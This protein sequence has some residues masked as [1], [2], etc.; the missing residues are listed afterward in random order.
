MPVSVAAR[1]E[2]QVKRL[3]AEI[4]SSNPTYSMHVFPPLSVLRC[5]V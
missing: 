4:M 3:D 5:T 2:A 1:S